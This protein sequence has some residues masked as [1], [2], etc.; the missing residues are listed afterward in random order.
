MVMN[1]SSQLLQPIKANVDSNAHPTIPYIPPGNPT[2]SVATTNTA[3]PTPSQSAPYI[4]LGS[5]DNTYDVGDI[6]TINVNIDTFGEEIDEFDIVIEFDPT[7]IEI[8]DSDAVSSGIQINFLDT[9]FEVVSGGNIVETDIIGT[10]TGLPGRITLRANSSVAT[11]ITDRSV[12][13]IEF[14]VIS[15]KTSELTIAENSS[16]LISDSVNILETNLLE[17][18]VINSSGI[19][20]TPTPT[21][22]VTV[23]TPSITPITAISSPEGMLFA[24][25]GTLLIISGIF[26]RRKSKTG[27]SIDDL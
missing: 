16:S 9:N 3:T 11:T 25:G 21:S 19:E 13:E 1:I 12:A 15:A 2:P 24:I 26:L 4:Y 14:R 27:N 18:F 7:H 17:P 5:D 20:E 23:P 6:G 8:I 10:E 22:T